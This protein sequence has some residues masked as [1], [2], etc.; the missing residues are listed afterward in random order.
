MYGPGGVWWGDRCMSQGSGG[1]I[2]V[3]A[4]GGVMGG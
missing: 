3:W 2:G 4:R 1:G